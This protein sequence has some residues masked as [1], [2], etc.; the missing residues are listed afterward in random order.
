VVIGVQHQR[1]PVRHCLGRDL[2]QVLCY[3]DYPELPGKKKQFPPVKFES[4]SILIFLFF[5]VATISNL[6]PIGYEHYAWQIWGVYIKVLA[7]YYLAIFILHK[8]EHYS[9][10]IWMMLFSIGIMAMTQGARFLLSAG[11]HR[12][13]TLLGVTG[14]NNFFGV[15][16]VTFIPLTLYLLTQT[17]HPL[18]RKILMGMIAFI[19]LGLLSTYSRGA[20]IGLIALMLYFIKSS[21]RKI[22]WLVV[23]S[24]LVVGFLMV[25]PDAWMD[26]MNTIN[27]ADQDSSFM[28]RVVSWKM[29]FLIASDHLFGGGFKA[30]EHWDVWVKYS[31]KIH[32]LDFIPTPPPDPL[33]YHAFHSIY[34]QVLG[35]H[36]FIGLFLFLSILAVAFLK[37]TRFES[38]LEKNDP[39]GW[40]IRLV[41]M[42]K[43]SLFTYSLSG[44]A[45]NV[46]YYDFFYIILAMIVSIDLRFIRPLMRRNAEIRAQQ[47][48][49]RK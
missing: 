2:Q 43:I 7:M 17:K 38:I 45:V 29:G 26:R 5:I 15:V 13:S 10:L 24:S 4:I 27:S 28:S 35:N 12:F 41:R 6:N 34:F 8:R 46:A 11:R 31:A 1:N 20:F 16:L 48:R 14:D 9:L 25:V 36:G 40:L 30:I 32:V 22:L 23:I 21:D 18:A 49:E 33:E 3:L 37:L 44:A 47:M 39:E 19:F 42:L